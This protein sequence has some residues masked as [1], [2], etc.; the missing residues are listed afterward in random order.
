MTDELAGFETPES[1]SPS[2]Q[3][4]GARPPIPTPRTTRAKAKEAGIDIRNPPDDGKTIEFKVRK[5]KK[6]Q[7]KLAAEQAL[8][9]IEMQRLAELEKQA[10]KKRH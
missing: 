4:A 6:L 8:H 1:R 10:K 5:A 3:E 9:D 7:E 2:P